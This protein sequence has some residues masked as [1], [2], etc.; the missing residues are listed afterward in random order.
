MMAPSTLQIGE[1]TAEIVVFNK[2][3]RAE[4][5][6]RLQQGE[7]TPREF[8]YGFLDLQAAGLDVAM[9]SSAGAVP[10]LAGGAADVVE[11]GF[12]V[13]T[14]FGARP[15]SARLLAARSRGAKVLIS[16]TDGL[17]LSLG[18]A[19][20]RRKARPILIGGF[21]GLADAET[22]A[23]ALARAAVRCLVR[24]ALSGLDHAF[25][26]GPADRA[27]AIERYG[28]APGRSS[29]LPFGAD[30]SY[31]RPLPDE[32][33]ADVV[34]AVG[35]DRNRD[36]DLLAATPGRHPIRIV[37][38]RPVRIP[39]GATNVQVTPGDFYGSDSLSDDE[40]RRL[41]NAARAVVVPL[42]DVW[43]P[44]GQSVTMQAM[45]CGRPVI[46]TQTRG[47]WAPD[48]I[49]DGDNCLLVPPGDA[50][51]LAAAIGRLRSDPDLAARLGSRA[52]ATVLQHFGLDQIGAGAVALA[53]LGLALW[54]QRRAAPQSQLGTRVAGP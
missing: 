44:S 8:F 11:R 4:R 52:R 2:G 42:R 24:R 40:L 19:F 27:V 15:L 6:Q 35:Q 46:L 30:T 47:L 38:R 25:F 54:A 21:H 36:Y 34:V 32:P 1:A 48:L 53:R 14:S 50:A 16:Y 12:A 23:P 13:L 5:L 31:W 10:G 22:R 43:Q 29:V 33:H 45:S 3:G 17:S 26:L 7:E 28:L 18:L 39:D 49:R 9:V 41:Y 37:T 51:A 20:P